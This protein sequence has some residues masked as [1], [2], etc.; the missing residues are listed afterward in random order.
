MGHPPYSPDIELCHF[1]LFPKI[2]NKLR[3]FHYM[4][5]EETVAA[6]QTDVSKVSKEGLAEYI[7]QC[8]I[9]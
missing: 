5:A 1:Y 4:N 7:T 9:A 3:G 6:F 2:E 8:F